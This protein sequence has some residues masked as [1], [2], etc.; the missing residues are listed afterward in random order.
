MNTSIPAEPF[1]PKNF[2]DLVFLMDKTVETLSNKYQMSEMDS[3][4]LVNTFKMAC[5]EY[6]RM[7]EE[8]LVPFQYQYRRDKPRQVEHNLTDISLCMSCF[9]MT[10]SIDI[11]GRLCCGHCKEL[12]QN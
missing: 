8:G 12:K 7:V 11:N 3:M 2:E 6:H 4:I 1:D 10:R 9:T 5:G